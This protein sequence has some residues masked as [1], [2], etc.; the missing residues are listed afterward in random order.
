VEHVKTPARESVVLERGTL[1]EGEGCL[2][3]PEK[4]KMKGE[5]EKKKLGREKS[6]FKMLGVL[7]S[8]PNLLQ[9]R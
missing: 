8:S 7:G 1:K 9:H 6:S 2:G 5:K 3:G 4:K